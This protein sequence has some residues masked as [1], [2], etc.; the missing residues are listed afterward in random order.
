MVVVWLRKNDCNVS[1][2]AREF[3]VDRKR[4]REWNQKYKVLKS[5]SVG[6]KAKRRK[7]GECGRNPLSTDLD[8]HVFRYLEEERAEGRVVT[9]SN[10]TRTALGFGLT[11]FKASP[12]WLLRWK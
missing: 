1:K 7:I 9:N 6:S 3:E 4:V 11:S 12:G 10:L 8:L 2:A 5:N